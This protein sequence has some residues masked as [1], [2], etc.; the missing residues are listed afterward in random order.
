M[1]EPSNPGP[2]SE[3][4]R[5][6]LSAPA[7]PEMMEL[8]HAVLE[9]LWAQHDDVPM[10][11]RIRFE[12]AVIEVL[13]NIVEHAYRLEPSGAVRRFDVSLSAT[14]EQLVASFGDDG[15]PVAIDLSRVTMPE[16]DA[17]SGRG[18]ALA[19]AALD[20]LQYVR[21]GD[22]NQW[23]LICHRADA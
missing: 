19:M 6:E 22:R 10:V 17:E 3:D 23:T 7:T 14:D 15:I 18:L 9:Q 12:T 11:D 5:V 16:E 1:P 4:G 8:V 20:D 21:A 2:L 13:G